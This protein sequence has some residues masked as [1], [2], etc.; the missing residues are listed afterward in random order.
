MADLNLVHFA[1]VNTLEY[2]SIRL[3]KTRQTVL[4]NLI[5]AMM[6]YKV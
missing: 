5:D 4:D 1:Q 2:K 6:D 3:Q